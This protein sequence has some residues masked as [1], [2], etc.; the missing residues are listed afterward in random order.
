MAARTIIHSTHSKSCSGSVGR[1]LFRAS[2]QTL[3]G[4]NRAFSLCERLE[5]VQ[6]PTGHCCPCSV[7]P[8]NGE[9]V[10]QLGMSLQP[11]G[12]ASQTCW[13]FGTNLMAKMCRKWQL[14][15]RPRGIQCR[16]SETGLQAS[17]PSLMAV[18]LS[19]TVLL[20]QFY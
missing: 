1:S 19:G 20:V 4:Q 6:H 7:L 11:C 14:G 2:S 18:L 3:S 13:V 16:G 9:A 12:M 10:Q 5:S 8:I 17:L 15:T